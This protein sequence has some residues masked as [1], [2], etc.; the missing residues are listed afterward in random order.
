MKRKY[1]VSNIE[2]IWIDDLAYEPENGWGE[3]FEGSF[4]DVC[5]GDAEYTLVSL[6]AL[7]WEAVNFELDELAEECRTI[8]EEKGVDT[9]IGLVG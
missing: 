9:L 5:R 8:R 6:S 7:Y 1:Q 2:V 4:L 3:L